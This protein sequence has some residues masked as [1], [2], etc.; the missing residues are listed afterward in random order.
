[1]FDPLWKLA[2]GL[3]TGMV[4]GL[5]LQKGRVAKFHVIVNQFL[6]RDWT[7]VK[8]MGTAVVVG[9]IGIYA[10]LPTGAVSLHIKPLVWLGIVAGGLCFGAGMAIF[11]YC[12]GTSVAAC[13]EGRRD[14]MVGVI[15]MLL[16]A[17][18][19]VVLYPQLSG[20]LKTWGDAGK[21][22]LPEWSGTS[23]WLWIGVVC[24][25]ALAA[26]AVFD[27]SWGDTSPRLHKDTRQRHG[28]S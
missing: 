7:V 3:L 25:G 9:A 4:F 13:G 17:G 5:L 8:I 20:L 24:F 2:L 10:L 26:F 22:T 11:G 6:F 12:P 28:A 27:R 21:V 23:P 14:A 19:Y 1:M 15:G 18:L 16:G